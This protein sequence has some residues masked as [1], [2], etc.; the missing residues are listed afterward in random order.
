LKTTIPLL[1]AESR[2]PE[3][4]QATREG[5]VALGGDLSVERLVL[6]YQSGIF[7]WTVRPLTWWSP[8][9]RG[10]FE[11]DAFHVSHSLHKKLKRNLFRVTTDQAFRKVIEGCARPGPGR[12]TTWISEQFIEAYT[13]LH[14][15]GYAHSIECWQGEQL[16]GG[17]YGVAIGGLF[18]GESMF[19]V[20][21]DA[22]KIALYHLVEHLKRRKFSLFDIQM[23]TAITAQLG[24]TEIGRTEYLE[25]LA[26]ATKQRCVF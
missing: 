7:P 24:A 16:A 3:P 13:H 26:R 19:H 4:R 1:R 2:F 15:L 25:R 20:V 17:I 14:E 21:T 5:L 11:L 8:D 22:S 10:I 18:A 6:A 23:V 9:P 12:R